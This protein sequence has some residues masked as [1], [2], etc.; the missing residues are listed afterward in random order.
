MTRSLVIQVL[1][2]ES[3]ESSH[4]GDGVKGATTL[5]VSIQWDDEDKDD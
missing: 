2:A 3:L 5:V 4:S 1:R